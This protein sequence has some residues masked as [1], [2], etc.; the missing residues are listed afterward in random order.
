MK[1]NLNINSNERDLDIKPDVIQWRRCENQAYFKNELKHFAS[2]ANAAK[3]ES[4][5][6]KA[7]TI[8]KRKKLNEYYSLATITFQNIITIKE[9]LMTFPGLLT[10]KAFSYIW[11][12]CKA[13]NYK[14]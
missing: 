8:L 5:L 14:M 6:K 9:M 10:D 11:K 1:Y 13:L 4:K 3:I 12:K 7:K 2:K